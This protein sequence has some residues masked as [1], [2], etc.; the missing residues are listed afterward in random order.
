MK[1]I[2]RSVVCLCLVVPTAWA[3]WV[4]ESKIEGGAT[5]GNA[6]TKIK[7]DKIRMDLSQGR[8]G[9][10]S[11]ILD[12]KTGDMINLMHTPKV[13]MK[14]SGAAFKEQMTAAG[15]GKDPAANPKP[16][17]TGQKEMVGGYEC[18]I[19]KR[20]SEK[21]TVTFWVVKNHPQEAALKVLAKT[22]GTLSGEGDNGLPGQ[23]LRTTRDL[24]Q[25]QVRTEMISIKEQEVDAK[26]FEA[27]EGYREMSAPSAPVAK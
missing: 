26:E 27:P 3:D 8:F 16:E 14:I 13:V 6:V 25:L 17:P 12:G 1:L 2:L 24:G 5:A 15:K 20:T 23:I 21:G 22:V 7:G 9:P 11:V 4:I 10:T 18:E 19:W